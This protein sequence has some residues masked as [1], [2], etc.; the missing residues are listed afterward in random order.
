MATQMDY[1]EKSIKERFLLRKILLKLPKCY[2]YKY[3]FTDT[4]SY[5]LYDGVLMKFEKDTNKYLGRYIIEVKV[6]D[7]HYDEL[8]L[9]RKKITDLI[10]EVKQMDKKTNEECWTDIKS[11]IIYVNVTPQGSYWF[12]LTDIEP[13]K[14]EWNNEEHWVSTTDKS[15]GK[16]TKQ[17]TYL[18]IS[19]AKLNFD[20]TSNDVDPN[21]DVV[22]KKMMVSQ[23]QNRCLYQYLI[24]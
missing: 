16:I 5:D 3:Y 20:I 18:P 8:L 24:S 23:E 19:S 7:R 2:D 14:I 6:R 13:N 15:K 10:K 9:E 12:K 4:S 22:M 21:S 17:V 1:I 11:D